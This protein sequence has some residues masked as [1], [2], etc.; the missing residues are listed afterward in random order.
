MYKALTVAG[1]ALFIVANAWATAQRGYFA[2]GG[3][4]MF[5]M[6]PLF[7][8]GFRELRDDE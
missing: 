5:L 6:L 1:I 3:E 2:I 4:M 7:V 8:A